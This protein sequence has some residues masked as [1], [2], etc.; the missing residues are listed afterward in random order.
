MGCS[1]AADEV[2]LIVKS[3]MNCEVIFTGSVCNPLL[4][5]SVFSPYCSVEPFVRCTL[6]P[7]LKPCVLHHL[8]SIHYPCNCCRRTEDLFSLHTFPTCL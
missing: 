3:M 2:S 5:V 4:H 6:E 8:A 7:P 1:A